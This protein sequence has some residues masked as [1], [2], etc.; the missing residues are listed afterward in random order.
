MATSWHFRQAREADSEAMARILCGAFRAESE[1]AQERLRYL[2]S[3]GWRDMVVLEQDGEV[4]ATAHVEP[5]RLRVGSCSV[6]KADVGHVAVRPDLQARGL[7]T[8]L[9]KHLVGWLP[10]ARFH[11]SRLGGLMLYYERFGYEPF[12]R[13]YVTIP[14]PARDSELKGRRWHDLLAP[15]AAAAD[16][17]RP[18]HPARDY[19]QVH[20]LRMAASMRPGALVLPRD[21]GPAPTAGPD[22]SRLVSVYERN[23]SVVGYLRAGLARVHAD[24]PEPRYCLD[25]LAVAPWDAGVVGALVKTLMVRAADRVPTEITGRLPYDE[26][27]FEALT[28]AGVPFNVLEMRQALDGNM[29]QVVDLPGVLRAVAPELTRRLERAGCC[30]WSGCLALHL[31]R[32]SA[33][34]QVAPDKVTVVSPSADMTVQAITMSQAAF[35]KALFSLEGLPA[36]AAGAGALPGPV[37]VT[38]GILFPRLPAASGPWG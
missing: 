32:E 12:P 25:E 35:L 2:A 27:L 21:P 14:V 18:Y 7:G 37:Q 8:C 13:R 30:P 29:M 20:R 10:R 17:V 9:M 36:A 5:H 15:G 38:L 3:A 28:A 33:V 34:V 11:V 31:P 23:G 22:P 4:V 24:D 16:A 1:A 19:R 6:L 26:R